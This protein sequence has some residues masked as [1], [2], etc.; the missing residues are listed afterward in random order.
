[1]E[2][3]KALVLLAGHSLLAR[4]LA[5]M[6]AAPEVDRVVAVLPAGALPHWPCLEKEVTQLQPGERRKLAPPVVGG[7]QRQDSVQRGLASL[8]EGTTHVVVHDAAR[9]L[10]RAQQVGAVLAE[11]RR[12]GAALLA[13]PVR[14][15]LKRV[16]RQG[17]VCETV[18]RSDCWAAQTPQAFRLDWLR[19]AL[20]GAAAAGVVGTDDAALV[21]RIGLPVRVVEGDARN[22]KITTWEDL[23]LA[24]AWLRRREGRP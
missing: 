19:R 3:F 12:S 16:D 20:L 7:A 2:L 6:A 5:V 15:T 1:V 11:A 24:E 21:A 13:V 4:S 18:E 8:P 17:R 14:D 23:E 9:P 10:L 22:F